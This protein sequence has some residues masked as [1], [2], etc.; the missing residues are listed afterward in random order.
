MS[1][2]EIDPIEYMSL[3]KLWKREPKFVRRTK[4]IAEKYCCLLGVE[5]ERG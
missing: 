3:D 2:I 1:V 5:D 4:E